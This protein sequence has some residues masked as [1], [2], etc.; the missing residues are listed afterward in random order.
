MTEPVRVAVIGVGASGALAAVHLLRAVIDRGRGLH[1]VLVD[2]GGE[3]GPGLAYRTTDPEHLLNTPAGKMSAF[4][5]D[6]GHFVRWSRA[7][8]RE[9][10]DGT[11]LPRGDYGRYLTETLV[12]EEKRADGVATVERITATAVGLKPGEGVTVELDGPAPILADTVV[13]APGAGHGDPL[14]ALLPAGSDRYVAD[15][16][17]GPG[18]AAAADGSPVL[19]LG[20]GLSMMD[21][22]VS[23]TRTHPDTVVH[24]V[25]RHGLL[26]RPH[27]SGPPPEVAS[28]PEPPERAGSVRDLLGYARRCLAQE[29]EHWREFV[30]RLRPH[31]A[32]LWRQLEPGERR[33]FLDRVN[34]FW[35]VHRHRAAPAT[36]HRTR[37]L[38][39]SG[40]LRLHRGRVERV[41][42]TAA[43]FDVGLAT[44]A[45][46]REIPVGWL[47]NATGFRTGDGDPL[48]RRLFTDGTARPDQVGLGMA[49]GR[50]GRVLGGHDGRIYTL[51]AL[52]RGEEFEST[53]VPEI[54]SQAAAIAEATVGTR[55]EEV[56]RR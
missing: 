8:G 32:R 11:F 3:F 56:T 5:D 53:A 51:G 26:P 19:V 44:P 41:R 45:G 36:H 30:D 23:V 50:D 17:R 42:P 37:E 12:A 39:R 54:R 15:P 10:E 24:A 49:T 14:A 43:G 13:L 38:L 9:A 31:T 22:A 40:R 47:V 20:T 29:P 46:H 16:W 48:L 25:S 6:P 1:L 35:D 33:R 21:I 18:P 34:R 28:V 2:R 55:E 27:R 4:H 52:R 7:R